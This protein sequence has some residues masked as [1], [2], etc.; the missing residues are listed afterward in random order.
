MITYSSVVSRDGICIVL[1]IVALNDLNVPVCDIKNN[2]L[3][4]KCREKIWTRAG[5]KFGSDQGKFVIVV[6]SLY[7]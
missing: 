4:A 3:I 6:L 1:N 5:P 2:Y 7:G